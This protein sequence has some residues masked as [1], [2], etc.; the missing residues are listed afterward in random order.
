M[1][2][3][4]TFM[5]RNTSAASSLVIPPPLSADDDAEIIS[6]YTPSFLLSEP[7]LPVRAAGPRV[8]RPTTTATSKASRTLSLSL[9]RFCGLSLSLSP[10]LSSARD[11]SYRSTERQADAPLEEE[12]KEEAEEGRP[13]ERRR[14]L[15][16]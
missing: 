11:E 12:E 10:L 13:G 15:E 6:L 16:K 4:S 1:D 5:E 9:D 8:A 3:V 14:R 2:V 7:G